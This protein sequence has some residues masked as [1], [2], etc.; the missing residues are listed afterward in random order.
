E[1]FVSGKSSDWTA[2]APDDA[3]IRPA[4]K[5]SLIASASDR[6][7]GVVYAYDPPNQRLIALDKVTGKVAGQYRI[8]AG[9]PVKGFGD[10]RGAA[11]IHG[12]GSD[13]DTFLWIDG[14]HLFRAVL[15]PVQ[16][17]AG[18]SG[19]AASASPSARRSASPTAP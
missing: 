2:A 3:A 8:V 10:M 6:R 11:V 17:P 19:A 7:V 12:S 15:A 4:P 18:G 9:G 16:P 5:Y 13:P 1:R 14:T